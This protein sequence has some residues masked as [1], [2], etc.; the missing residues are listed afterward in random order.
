MNTLGTSIGTVLTQRGHPIAYINKEISPKHSTSSTYEWEMY[1]ILVAIRKW[2]HYLQGWPFT[3]K[4]YHRSLKYLLE[5]KS[6][7]PLQHTQ[8][9]TLVGLD[10]D[11]QYNKGRDNKV[12]NALS[13]IHDKEPSFMAISTLNTDLLQ[14]IQDSRLSDPPHLQTTIQWLQQ[15]GGN[16]RTTY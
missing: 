10:F 16:K 1:V 4:T 12:A 5:Q 9:I 3:I 2:S 8:L 7:A 6:H 13:R 15:Q 14:Q 11:I